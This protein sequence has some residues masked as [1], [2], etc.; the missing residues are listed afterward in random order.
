[1]PMLSVKNTEIYYKE[2]GQGEPVLL[3]HGLGCSIGDYRFQIKHL[4]K[5]FHVFAFD[6]RGHGRSQKPPGPYSIK[7]FADDTALL[8][9]KVIGKPAHIIGTS[10]G[11]MTAFQ[12]AVDKP[13]LVK[14]L[15]IINSGP[16]V[17]LKTFKDKLN[18]CFRRIVI[19]LFGLR[20]MG[21]ILAEKLF[22]H[23]NQEDIRRNFLA[24]WA[25]N[26]MHSYKSSIK[27]IV[28]WSVR[29]RINEISAPA[30]IIS[31]DQD[32]T[33]IDTKREYANE[34]QNAKL[35]VIENSGHGTPL[36]QPEALNNEI[37]NFINT[38][39]GR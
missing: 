39:E 16:E 9:T 23:E 12:L 28:G 33:P 5:N 24:N 1:M 15:I 7:L 10:L 29:N 21:T 27:A 32:Y 4:Q 38:L 34:M 25:Q 20:K 37:E 3:I 26:N 22:P 30:L 31:G 17:L 2:F 8:I 14:S 6:L 11:G 19:R 13:D 35:V 36:D 18:Y